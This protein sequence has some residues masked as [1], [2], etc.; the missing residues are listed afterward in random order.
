MFNRA[1]GCMKRDGLHKVGVRVGLMR[2]VIMLFPVWGISM[3][4]YLISVAIYYAASRSF[5]MTFRHGPGSAFL[6]APVVVLPRSIGAVVCHFCWH[7]HS[8]VPSPG[9]SN[10]YIEVSRCSSRSLLTAL[11]A[12][13]RARWTDI[14]H[15]QNVLQCPS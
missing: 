14:S 9:D 12:F 10:R 6:F 2:K 1:V 13:D 4:G 7:G 3:G 15:C 5:V 11:S 8:Y